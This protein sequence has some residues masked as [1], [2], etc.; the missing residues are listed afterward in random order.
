M[1]GIN[2][3]LLAALFY[4]QQC[5]SVLKEHLKCVLETTSQFIIILI[6]NFKIMAIGVTGAGI[7]TVLFNV[8]LYNSALRV[9]WLLHG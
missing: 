4:V 6:K 8:S 1:G 3:R 7:M 5:L 9:G 2:L